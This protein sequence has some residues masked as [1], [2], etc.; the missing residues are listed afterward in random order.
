VVREQWLGGT[1]LAVPFSVDLTSTVLPPGSMTEDGPCTGV[2]VGESVEVQ[3]LCRPYLADSAADAQLPEAVRQLRGE[4]RYD[5]PQWA[6]ATVTRREAWLCDS[7]LLELEPEDEDMAWSMTTKDNEKTTAAVLAATTQSIQPSVSGRTRR[8]ASRRRHAGAPRQQSEH[9]EYDW[10]WRAVVRTAEQVSAQEP[11]PR[12]W[13]SQVVVLAD[14]NSNGEQLPVPVAWVS[15]DHA[16][17]RRRMDACAAIMISRPHQLVGRR[18]LWQWPSSGD[19]GSGGRRRRM[20]ARHM[21]SMDG[22]WPV[23]QLTSATVLGYCPEL[24][25]HAVDPRDFS[26][27]HELHDDLLE[28]QTAVAS[29]LRLVDLHREPFLVE[30]SP[31]PVSQP[32]AL[33]PPGTYTHVCAVCLTAKADSQ[34]VEFC[35]AHYRVDGHEVDVAEPRH[36]LSVCGGCLRT[37]AASQLGAGKISVRCPA[38][39]CGRALQTRELRHHTSAAEFQKLLDSLRAAEQQHDVQE[40]SAALGGNVELRHCPQCRVLIEKNRGCSHMRCYRCDHSF[41][42]QDAPQPGERQRSRD[43]TATSPRRRHGAARAAARRRQLPWGGWRHVL[44][45]DPEGIRG[46]WLGGAPLLV[47]RA[48]VQQSRLLQPVWQSAI[49]ARVASRLGPSQRR[50]VDAATVLC[51]WLCVWLVLCYCTSISWSRAGL[52]ILVMGPFSAAWRQW[53][54]RMT[55]NAV[56]RL[57]LL[58]V[59]V[60]CITH[61]VIIPAAWCAGSV[62]SSLLFMLG[63]FIL[64]LPLSCIFHWTRAIWWVEM[65]MVVAAAGVWFYNY[66]AEMGREW[67]RSARREPTL[68]LTVLDWMFAGEWPIKWLLGLMIFVIYGKFV[69]LLSTVRPRCYSV[70]REPPFSFFGYLPFHNMFD[71]LRRESCMSFAQET[72]YACVDGHCARNATIAHTLPELGKVLGLTFTRDFWLMCYWNSFCAELAPAG[73]LADAATGTCV[74]DLHS[75]QPAT[76]AACRGSSDDDNSGWNLL[77]GIVITIVPVTVGR[78]VAFAST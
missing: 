39:G 6:R 51:I 70:T 3:L 71:N 67:R 25:M 50:A 55:D 46:H 72:G 18:V 40:V 47:A 76:G 20:M 15:T 43:S 19:D 31:L 23:H 5:Q 44:E 35:Y 38:S 53:A 65:A 48:M 24:G 17:L 52:T 1:R 69:L 59:A 13:G 56:Q 49:G 66:P 77:L 60:A 78:C 30:P 36:P 62:L 28:T 4:G 64:C 75:A 58:H 7:S 14:I 61:M 45:Y 33:A 57:A 10:V 37:H 22:K 26:D 74:R 63:Y 16:P 11:E 68:I 12:A 32:G 9:T 27:E 54:A 29:E 42:W 34:F 73:F 21:S 2:A 8:L 41:T